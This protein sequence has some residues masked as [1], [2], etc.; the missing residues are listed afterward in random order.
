MIE[1]DFLKVFNEVPADIFVNRI[2]NYNPVTADNLKKMTE[3]ITSVTENILPG[4]E[5]DCV[6]YGCT[7]G[8]IVSGY[9][10]IKKKINLAKPNTLVTT[11]STAALNALKKKN[12]KK[13]SIVTPYIKSVNDDVV[14]FFKDN[15]FEI[16]SNT[17]F[18]IE[19]DIDIGRVD[20]DKLFEILSKIDHKDAEALFVSCTS[21]PV[22]NI[23]EKLEKKLGITVLSSNQ[24]L[25]W[26]TLEYINI[27]N[28]IKGYGSLFS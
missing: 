2:T 24:A 6:V 16:T 8:T 7:S 11:P 19:S 10:N 26:E 4:E 3:N 9:D 12:I 5:V 18:D 14:I 23:I 17:Y 21:L 15:N 13:I 27:N 22:L 28:S 20:Q 1:K 25:I